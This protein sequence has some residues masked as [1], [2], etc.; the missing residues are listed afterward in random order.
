M[1]NFEHYIKKKIRFI[2]Y[3]QFNFKTKFSLLMKISEKFYTC[4]TLSTMCKTICSENNN[5]FINTF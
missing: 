1:T 4:T 3:T 5:Y 2:Y